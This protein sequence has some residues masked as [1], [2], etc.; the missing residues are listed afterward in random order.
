MKTR[1]ITSIL[2]L[3]CLLQPSFGD[4]T[5]SSVYY[6]DNTATYGLKSDEG[7]VLTEKT[8]DG[9]SEFHN[10]VAIVKKDGLFGVISDTGEE[11]VVPNYK[12]IT[13]YR[14][15]YASAFIGN[16]AGALNTNGQLVVPVEYDNISH[17]I[18]G[19]ALAYKDNKL[20]L[21]S[22][23]NQ[24]I[25][26][27]VWDE[28]T[29]LDFDHD[30]NTFVF[31]QG[32]T[33]GVAS[34]T[35]K[36]IIP[37][38]EKQL[39]HLSDSQIA[40]VSDNKIGVMNHSGDVIIAPT[41]ESIYVAGK[42]YMGSKDDHYYFFNM[43]NGLISA[44]Y[45]AIN[46]A[47]NGHYLVNENGQY[48]IYDTTLHKE[49]IAPEYNDISLLQNP[50]DTTQFLFQVTRLSSIRDNLSYLGVVS[51]D[52][53]ILLPALYTKL[54]FLSDQLL[55]YQDP[56]G[57]MGILNVINGFDSG[58]I[59]HSI[60]Y[61]PDSGLSIVT[62]KEK[63]YGLIDSDGQTLIPM[64][65]HYIYENGNFM[66]AE[67]DDK[68]AL[69][70]KEKKT[71][72]PYKY[73]SIFSFQSIGETEAAIISINNL[74]GLLTPEGTYLVPPEFDAINEFV[75]GY[76]IVSKDNKYGFINTKGELVVKPQFE[77]V[78]SFN[79]GFAIARKGGKYGFIQSNGKFVV[80]AIY[81]HVKPFD[82]NGKSLVDYKGRMGMINKDG[83]YFLNPVY[84]SIKPVEDK[85]IVVQDSATKKY[86]ILKPN[87]E[88]I[89][90]LIYDDFG[91][92]FNS[93][94]TYVEINGKF[95]VINNKGEVLTQFIFDDMTLFN[96]GFATVTIG[97]QKGFINVR[98]EYIL[99]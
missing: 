92:F 13:N 35:G 41:Y 53:D 77:D 47:G 11:L 28:A 94:A 48:G 81:D 65:N 32:A 93:T 76:A 3:A 29:M 31:K 80:P 90:K 7:V 2:C 25:H 22:S 26:P 99:E 16:L 20:G 33:Y 85:I 18:N 5:T 50:H 52:G 24:V 55:I 51:M 79:D 58:L 39:F 12:Y 34:F 43:D 8:Y 42:G 64:T 91:S 74:W 68:K 70:S 27:F 21:I 88:E 98:G 17:F 19:H 69:F 57:T 97:E 38:Q 10:G 37:A 87:G 49:V 6:D 96:K 83:S 23:T 89:S 4:A 30:Y 84:A 73:D 63:A 61:D 66:I 82:A 62:S 9:I 71:L 14:N 44:P 95:A 78:S 46:D 54:S 36:I 40:F 45:D 72:S 56:Q 15:G 86:G 67:K 59:Y 60:K 75:N 1:L